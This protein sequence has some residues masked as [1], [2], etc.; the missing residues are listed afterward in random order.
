[1]RCASMM[2]LKVVGWLVLGAVLGAAV[3]E[4][5]A[6]MRRGA[7]HMSALLEAPLSRVDVELA[8]ERHVILTDPA[9]LRFLKAAM[10][11]TQVRTLSDLVRAAEE[12]RG[13]PTS[14]RRPA[15]LLFSDGS[16]F[17]CRLEAY[18][19]HRGL[20]VDVLWGEF[21]LDETVYDVEFPA[22]P[23]TPLAKLLDEM[24][25]DG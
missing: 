9:S 5:C 14:G 22:A 16:T 10:A 11:M 19:E 18:P 21:D 8:H 12:G 24:F 23:P 7:R 4:W 20:F 15:K 3:V 6:W 2:K 1:M 17:T 25:S 13:I